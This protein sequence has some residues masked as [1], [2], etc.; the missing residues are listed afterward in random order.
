MAADAGDAQSD[1]DADSPP[2]NG[3]LIVC[4]LYHLI[5]SSVTVISVLAKTSAGKSVSKIDL[6]CVEWKVKP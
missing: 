6:F 5:I 1:S 4:H 3:E 2:N